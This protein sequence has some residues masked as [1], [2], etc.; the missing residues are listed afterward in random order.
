MTGGAATQ[1]GYQ[2]HPDQ[3]RAATAVAHHPVVVIGA[4]PVGLSFAIDLAE[5]GHPVV[6]LDDADRIGEGS[7]AICFSKRSLEYWDRLGVGGRMV[8]KGVVWNVGRIFHGASQLYQFNLLPEDGHKMPAFINLQQFYAEAYLVDRAAQLP[9]ISLR[10]RNKV[11]ALEQRNDHVVVTI[12]TPEGAYRL[13]ASHLI[14]CDGARSSLRS[15]VG[16]EFAGKVFED[17]FLI[18]DVKMTADFPTERWFWFDPPFH[19]GR[20]ALLHRQPDNV[21]RIDLQLS[22]DADPA[23]E[24][25]PENVRPRITRMLGHDN[26]DF[27]WISLYKFQ[28]RRMDRFVHGRVVFAGDS[29]HQVSPFGA[30]GA[31]SGLE[32]AENLAWKLSLVLDGR[33]SAALLDSYHVER[34]AAA[35]ENIR[36]STRAT[37]F[38]APTSREEERLRRAVLALA[39]DTDFGKRMVNGGR[40]SVPS[41]YDTLLSTPDADRWNGGVVPGASMLDA[42]LVA[43]DGKATYLTDAFIAAGRRFTVL[44][45]ANGQAAPVPEGVGVIRIGGEGLTDHAGLA[46]KRYDAAPGTAYLLRPDGYVA[47]RFRHPTRAALDAALARA[48]GAN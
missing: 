34:S 32:D 5:R 36:E 42:P 13:S 7:R 6:L 20:S 3:D 44:E 40:L 4:G 26:F 39:R 45:F 8:D 47:A 23:V 41:V 17:Q 28:C 11:T 29:A 24:K 19:A 37:D 21:W 10:W 16:A 1:F 2:R 9:G 22:P 18:A 12:E 35:D 38:M 27:E 14:A 46:K 33:A 48:A 43:H 30:R 15:M 31:N 25:L